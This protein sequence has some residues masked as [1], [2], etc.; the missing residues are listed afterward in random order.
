MQIGTITEVNNKKA[1]AKVLVDE[2]VSDWLPV[3]SIASAFKKHFIPIK[4]DDQVMVLNPY[5][6]NENGFILRGIFYSEQNVPTGAGDNSE[7]IEYAD[8]TLL[9]FDIENKIISINTPS[10]ITIVC[11]NA[12]VEAKN[13]DVK[14]DTVKID[15]KSID[16]GLGGK[17]VI[18]AESM[19]PFTGSPHIDPSQNT[20]SKK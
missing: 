12:K 18:T 14:A 8:G 17:G 5:G 2:R 20:R 3:L 6:N 7:V 10:E 19:C 9:K 11:E 1:L 4:I 15:S 16:L 13:V